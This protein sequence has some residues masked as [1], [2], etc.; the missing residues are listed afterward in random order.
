ME[1]GLNKKEKW[2]NKEEQ[3]GEQT[4][5]EGVVKNKEHKELKGTNG[6]HNQNKFVK[7]L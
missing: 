2:Q 5:N 7:K 3:E 6:G 4:T 1:K